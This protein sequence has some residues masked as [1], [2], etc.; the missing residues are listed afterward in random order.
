MFPLFDASYPL[1]Q[2]VIVSLAVRS[3]AQCG[4]N[5]AFVAILDCGASM[6]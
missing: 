6:L 4:V 2:P 5:L 1:A 3:E